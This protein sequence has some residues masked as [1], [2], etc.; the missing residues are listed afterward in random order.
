MTWLTFATWPTLLLAEFLTSASRIAGIR[1]EILPTEV[2]WATGLFRRALRRAHAVVVNS[3][4]LVDEATAWGALA[5]KVRVIPNGVDLPHRVSDPDSDGAVVLANY[6]PYKG[7]AD[8]LRAL[9]LCRSDVRVNLCGFGEAQRQVE[10]LAVAL[11][12]R[13]RVHFVEQPADV[14]AEL[15]LAGFA[16][17]PSHTEGLSNAILEEMAAGLPVV[18]MAVGGNPMLVQPGTNGYLLDVGDHPALARAIDDLALSP[19]LRRRLGAG[20]RERVKQFTWETCA[21]RYQELLSRLE[22]REDRREAGAR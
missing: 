18:A 6:R 14:P 13:D 20:S 5:G 4:A 15:A 7:H 22:E 21:D 12:V 9:T 8:L 2:R 10:E 16:I 3:E 17:H 1:G 11:N 19:G